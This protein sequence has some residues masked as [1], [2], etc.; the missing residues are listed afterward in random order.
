MRARGF[1]PCTLAV[2]QQHDSFRVAGMR[3]SGVEAIFSPCD[4]EVL[5]HLQTTWLG[6]G[7]RT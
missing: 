1:G 2:P 6:S 7:C 4:V 5:N 3:L